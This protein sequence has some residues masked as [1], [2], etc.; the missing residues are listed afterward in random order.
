[1]IAARG[2]YPLLRMNFTLFP[3]DE[4]WAAE[5]PTELVGSIAPID[6]YA[7]DHMDARIT[8]EAPDNTRGVAQVTPEQSALMKQA[9]APFFRRTMADEIPW[10]GCH[11]PT[12][13]LAQEAGP[14]APLCVIAHSLGTIIASNYIYDL[15]VDPFKHL[16][17]DAP[18]VM[19]A[20]GSKLVRKLIADV[21]ARELPGVQVVGCASIAEARKAL[22]AGT[23]DLVTTA[24]SNT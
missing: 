7:C 22:D 6:L 23:V 3:C 17:S 18:R 16:I 12:N 5:A 1:M 19:V 4:P 21:L 10:V 9:A 8:V 20:D 2:A 15:Q 13:A 11:F 24:L 14:D